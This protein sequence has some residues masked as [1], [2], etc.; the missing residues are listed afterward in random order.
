MVSG[1]FMKSIP[2]R[3]TDKPEPYFFDETIFDVFRQNHFRPN[4]V[5]RFSTKLF[6]TKLGSYFFVGRHALSVLL[7]HMVGKPKRCSVSF[8]TEAFHKTNQQF[9]PLIS[10]RCRCYSYPNIY[11]YIY[12]YI[13]RYTYII[14]LLI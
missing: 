7:S 4:Y 9:R 2:Y 13:F 3:Q 14:Y 12:T 6:S 5:R 8:A 11:I 10:D 1:S